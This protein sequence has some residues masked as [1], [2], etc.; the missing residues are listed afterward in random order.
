MARQNGLIKI[1]GTLD[2]V[3][4]YKTKDGNLARMKT[5][6]DGRR[7]AADASFQRTRENNSEFGGSAV[8]AKL[9]RDILRPIS[10]MASDNRIVSRMTKLMT[11]IKNTDG[12]SIRGERNVT[13]GLATPEGVALF[14]G[15]E[16]NRNAILGSILLKPYA[17]LVPTSG[18]TINNLVPVNDLVF[19]EGATHASFTGAMAVLDYATGEGEIQLTNVQNVPLDAT[20]VNI[21][22][23]P[24]SLP[25]ISG[26]KVFLLKIEFFQMVN[27]QQYS[28]RNGAYNALKV[29]EVI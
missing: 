12:T 23:N 27:G 17:L 4:F 7:I 6:L 28:L 16:F 3:N 29:V 21:S 20:P 9:T 19:P 18:F 22:L 8:A 14:K 11:Q 13:E 1:K 26:T 25:A 15:F 24:A 5:S 2:N 10:L